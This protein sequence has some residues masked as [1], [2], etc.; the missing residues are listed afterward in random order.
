[1]SAHDTVSKIDEMVS[2]ETGGNF[3]IVSSLFAAFI[4]L[5]SISP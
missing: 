1:M 5:Y 2:G 3:S 4:P